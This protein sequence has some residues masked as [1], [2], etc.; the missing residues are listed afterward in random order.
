M[1]ETVIQLTDN[2]SLSDIVICSIGE[3]AV[4]R[5]R[6]TDD[7]LVINDYLNHQKNHCS[8]FPNSSNSGNHGIY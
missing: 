3:D 2:L 6:D 4:I 1:G 8:A 5:V 7:K